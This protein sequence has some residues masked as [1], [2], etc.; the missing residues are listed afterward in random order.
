MTLDSYLLSVRFGTL[1]FL[2]VRTISV[3]PI[4]GPTPRVAAD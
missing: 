2:T 1:L 4:A 3:S